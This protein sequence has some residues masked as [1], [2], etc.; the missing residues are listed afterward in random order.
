M[1]AATPSGR[2]TPILPGRDGITTAR[3]RAGYID[4]D[5]GSGTYHFELTGT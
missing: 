1:K 4:V 2:T 5:I 3:T